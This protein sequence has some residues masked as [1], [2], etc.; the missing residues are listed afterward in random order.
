MKEE[1]KSQDDLEGEK[2]T[3]SSDVLLSTIEKCEELRKKLSSQNPPNI[4][5]YSALAFPPSMPRCDIEELKEK[6]EKL[7]D[8]LRLLLRMSH[9]RIWRDFPE[10]LIQKIL[11]EIKDER[12]E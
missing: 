7:E 4:P 10:K 1:I 3:R 8:L 12:A 9:V 11:K 2:R 5:D 6:I